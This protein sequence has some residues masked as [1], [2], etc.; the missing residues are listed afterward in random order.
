MFCTK[1]GNKVD[2][3][4]KFCPD[5]GNKIE[6][7]EAEPII[8][9]E[10]IAPAFDA[11]DE[12]TVYLPE[13]NNMTEEKIEESPFLNDAPTEILREEEVT[14]EKIPDEELSEVPPPTDKGFFGDEKTVLLS[15][16]QNNDIQDEKTILL[17]EEAPLNQVSQEKPPIAN[18]DNY[19]TLT[20]DEEFQGNDSVFGVQPA[21][22]PV[23]QPGQPDQ[24][25]QPDQFGQPGQFDQY[26][27]GQPPMG[28]YGQADY[29]QN[30][31][32]VSPIAP[33]PEAPAAPV[34]VGA[35]RIF[36][37]S[38]VAFFAIIFMLSMSILACL[39]LGAS[40]SALNSRV[41]KLNLNTVLNAEF[42]GKDVSEN[43]YDTI[44]FS[45]VTHGNADLTDFKDYIKK[46]DILEYA[47]KNIENYAN[48]ILAGKGK[49]PSLTAEDITYDFFGENNDAADEVFDYEFGRKDLN[50]IQSNLEKENF[51]ENL[52]VKKWEKNIGID[53][54]NASYLVSYITIGILFALV[55]VLFIWIVIIVDKK[56]RH[57]MGFLGNILFIPGLV[58]FVCGLGVTVGSMIAFSLTSNVVFYLAYNILLDFGILALIIGFSELVL[59][60][61]FKKIGKKIK[62]KKKLAEVSEAV[63]QNPVPV[64]V[65]N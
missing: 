38:V 22:I 24:Y 54:Q 9:P 28:Q 41:K 46:S 48:Y 52:S 14:A 19:D 40:G 56:G 25:G 64:P 59:G 63:N 43:L 47:G 6:R 27:V 2:D 30:I 62:R 35:G 49:D 12:K 61:I 55:L 34:K 32:P 11:G 1:C 31:P 20:A 37:A 23:P 16:E 45:K 4:A 33:P 39:K 17:K 7:T 5:C 13:E 42:D 57:I 60:F 51:D 10:E 3:N 44:G 26:N 29:N 15:E 36:G 8:Q 50:Q 65:Y 21:A 58:V 53:P 18:Q